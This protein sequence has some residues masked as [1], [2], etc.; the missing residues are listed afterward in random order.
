MKKFIFIIMLF[1]FIF[2]TNAAY[3]LTFTGAIIKQH[4]E[5]PYFAIITTY[6]KGNTMNDIKEILNE[7]HYTDGKVYGIKINTSADLQKIISECQQIYNENKHFLFFEYFPKLKNPHSVV[8][9]LFYKTN[10]NKINEATLKIYP[11]DKIDLLIA[12]PISFN[13]IISSQLIRKNFFIKLKGQAE[14]LI[15][16]N[17][18]KVGATVLRKNNKGQWMD[19]ATHISTLVILKIDNKKSL[20]GIIKRLKRQEKRY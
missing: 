12:I 3:A 9:Y 4:R 14:I 11:N 5:L 7:K 17:S 19:I 18:F 6:H 2:L 15:P 16:S 8:V 10:F 13:P 20:Q 1:G